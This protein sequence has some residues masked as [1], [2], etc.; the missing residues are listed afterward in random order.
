MRNYSF[1]LLAVC[2]IISF[3]FIL[4]SP[5][6]AQGIFLSTDY[7]GIVVKPGEKVEIPL[8]I[9]NHTSAARTVNLEIVE[10]PKGWETNLKRFNR[11]VF[12]ALVMPG[13]KTELDFEV[14]VPDDV[15]KGIYKFVLR[16]SSRSIASNLT[17]EIKV[18]P[19][20][21]AGTS[22]V[23]DYPVLRGPSD[24]RFQ[25]SVDLVNE[26][27]YEQMYSLSAVAPPGW[28]VYF[29]PAYEDER[30]A[31]I[32]LDKG[33]T[34]GLEVNVKPPRFVKEGEYPIKVKALGSRSSAEAD[35]KVIITGDYELNLTTET[36]RLNMTAVAGRE[37]ILK[38][39]VENLGTK[40]INDITFDASEPQNWRVKFEP[41]RIKSL[42][43]GE[44]A[45]ITATVIPASRAIAGDYAF[46]ISASADGA[47]DDFELRVTVKTSTMWGIIGVLIIAGVVAGVYWLFQKYGRR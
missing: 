1:T 15:E 40:E 22:I 26:S 29:T 32:T 30:I 47:Y 36:G 21:A 14:D 6:F 41:E 18:D 8:E 37:N 28:E 33:A 19:E 10:G 25:F 46:T 38:L 16:A 3:V 7:P 39:R 24:A 31:S 5:A 11:E 42:A 34:K 13:Q 12:K 4:A 20:G 17:I 2:F 45:T 23:T 9:T 35:L 27:S 43:A 44:A